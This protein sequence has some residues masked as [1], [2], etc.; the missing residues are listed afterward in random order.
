M[1]VADLFAKKLP[2]P[3]YPTLPACDDNGETSVRGLFVVGE[4][5]GTP[6]LKLGI[7]AGARLA[8][9]LRKV[10]EA[11]L[12]PDG[13]TD[14]IVIGA[15]AAGLSCAL[16]CQRDG[17]SVVVVEGRAVAQTVVDMYR[18]K[19]LFAEPLNVKLEGPLWLQETDRETLLA[20]WHKQLKES[21][22]VAHEHE[23]V[24]DVRWLGDR[25]AVTT[26]KQTLNAKRVVLAVG[27]A[28]NPRK[29]GAPGEAQHAA[30]IRHTLSD[31][32]AHQNQDVVVYGG[33]DVAC[34]AA[35][36][37]MGHNR[38]TLITI[39]PALTFP[40]KRNKDAIDS[41]VAAGTLQLMLG[42]RLDQIDDDG[43]TA[44]GKRVKAELVFEMIGAEP[45]IAF[46]QKLGLTLDGAWT[47]KRIATAVL[48]FL[49]VYSLYALKKFPD[50]PHAWPFPL[51]I[52]QAG[53][54]AVVDAAFS[55]A[56]APFSWLF[57]DAALADMHRTLWFQ[58]GYLYS[59]AYTIVMIVFGRQALLRW[60]A[61]SKDP[62]YQRQRYRTLLAFQVVFF[63]LANVIAVQGLSLQ[64][65]WRAWGLYQP[66]PLFFN[67]FH[68]WNDSDPRAI[69]YFFIG[70]G[71]LGTFVAIP[72]L[73]WKNGKRFCTW[74]CGCGGLAETLGDR[75]R[76]LAPK[77]KRSRAWEVQGLAVLVAAALVTVIT[78]GMYQTRAD[79]PWAL[80]YAY[81]VDFWL[82]AVIPIGLY[83]FFGGKIWCRYW[84]PLAAWN[85]ILARWYGRLGIVSNDQCISCGQCSKQCQVGV[86]VMA[87]ARQGERFDN[88]NSS[89]IH[90]G[91]C[92][93][94]CPVDVLS[95]ST[96]KVAK[97]G[98][99]IV[100]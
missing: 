35:L 16:Q 2:E 30:R 68:W 13:M 90:C 23:P 1:R 78:V 59:L 40:K 61:T 73:S 89:C 91:I 45:P 69:L 75:F 4:A 47:S 46:F 41:A 10:H 77:G 33:G 37:L 29:A 84:C 56:F 88:V 8:R 93:D 5:A 67:T 49:A 99:P 22:V 66:W 96:A 9:H 38:V 100:T 31:P 63:L 7:N 70:F 42:T 6:L 80:A 36:A 11:H 25:F 97:K 17:L 94:V 18:G 26:S 21:G 43:V 64:H 86:D 83:P 58:Q 85:Q 55:V 48:V 3:S 74:V 19:H 72:L 14:V 81:V 60:T 95:F 79:N 50:L 57:T 62:R 15:G 24:T 53:F 34:E 65:A 98:L 44:G 87:F 82:V 28:G 12:E 54:A 20:H 39:D 71:L 27:K 92:V 76:H 32:Q 52:D 51:F